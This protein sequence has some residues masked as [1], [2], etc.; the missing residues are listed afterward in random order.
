MIK[1]EHAVDGLD[2]VVVR[3]RAVYLVHCRA[4]LIDLRGKEKS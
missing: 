4:I 3:E 1:A 2:E